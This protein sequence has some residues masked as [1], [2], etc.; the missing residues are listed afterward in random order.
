M[1]S[2]LSYRSHEILIAI[3]EAF[4]PIAFVRR[5]IAAGCIAGDCIVKGELSFLSVDIL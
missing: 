4:L 5:C 1:C 2:R 3:N